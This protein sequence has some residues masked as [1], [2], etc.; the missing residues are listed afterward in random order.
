MLRLL[1]KQPTD[2]L[3]RPLQLDRRE[4]SV[5]ANYRFAQSVAREA[6]YPVAVNLLP[7]I[8]LRLQMNYAIPSTFNS[9]YGVKV[10]IIGLVNP[11]AILLPKASKLRDYGVNI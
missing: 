9:G 2:I 6:K 4:A 1:E 10:W 11:K 7:N 3:E 5:A 8:Q